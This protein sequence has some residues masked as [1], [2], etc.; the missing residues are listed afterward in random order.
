MD[1]DLPLDIRQYIL[2]QAWRDSRDM[3]D[4][5]QRADF[6]YLLTD[7]LSEEKLEQ[8]IGVAL[9]FEDGAK[10]AWFLTEFAAHLADKPKVKVAAMAFDLALTL[11]YDDQAKIIGRLATVLPSALLVPAVDRLLALPRGDA[12]IKA[13][14]RFVPFLTPETLETTFTLAMQLPD[15]SERQE[16][17]GLLGSALP[18]T[19][20][21][22]AVEVVLEGSRTHDQIS[23][24]I[25]LLPNLWGRSLERALTAIA[26]SIG[27]SSG[28]MVA[29]QLLSYLYGDPSRPFA[30]R[31]FI[32]ALFALRTGHRQAVLDSLAQRDCMESLS[33]SPQSSGKLVQEV[34]DICDTWHWS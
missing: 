20:A 15:E 8:A 11:D 30:R 13:L 7:N 33:L 29:E 24:L 2:Q 26:L 3:V 18:T 27:D 12:R 14:R 17:I 10:R 6:L 28:S 23:A 32:T 9:E 25:E 19:L 1:A 31:L 5:R 4:E 34:S 22:R 21:E 16:L